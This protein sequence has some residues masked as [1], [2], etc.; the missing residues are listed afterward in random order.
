MGPARYSF[1]GFAELSLG[2]LA[3]SNYDLG[4]YAPPTPPNHVTCL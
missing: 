1:Y 3:V 2:S 4:F